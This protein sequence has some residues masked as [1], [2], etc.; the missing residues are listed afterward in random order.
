MAKWLF[1][2]PYSVV[3]LSSSLPNLVSVYIGQCKQYVGSYLR[4]ATLQTVGMDTN[5]AV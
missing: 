4:S 2:V 3:I 1:A 5:N